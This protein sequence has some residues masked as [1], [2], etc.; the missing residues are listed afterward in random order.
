MAVELRM[1]GRVVLVT[2]AG[3]GIGRSVVR[4]L[5]AEGAKIIAVD[6]RPEGLD[7]TMGLLEQASVEAIGLVG[8][9]SEVSSVTATVEAA[10][11]RFGEIDVLVNNAGVVIAGSVHELRIEDWDRVFSVNVRGALLMCRAVLPSMIARGHGVIVNTASISGLVGEP[12]LAAYNSSKGAVV[13]FTR[14]LAVDYGAAGIRC[15]CVCPGWIDTGFNQPIF[16][17]SNMSEQDVATLV[18]QTVPLNRQGT[19]DEVAAA[20]AFL[21]CDDASYVSGHALVVDGGQMA[22]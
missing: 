12:H 11:N 21:A 14:H 8:D 16:D 6:L 10:R 17:A 20:V 1:A 2:G 18:S 13:N 15:N 7:E 19:P 4:R 3:H 22:L 5:G 9:V